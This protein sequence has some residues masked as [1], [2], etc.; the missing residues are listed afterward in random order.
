MAS[1]DFNGKSDGWVWAPC[2]SPSPSSVILS[3]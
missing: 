3:G 1:L 2:F